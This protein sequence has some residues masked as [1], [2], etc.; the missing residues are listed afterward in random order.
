[1]E[2]VI[3]NIFY[4][5]THKI[6][7]THIGVVQTDSGLFKSEADAE[8][9]NKV[10]RNAINHIRDEV[11]IK[12]IYSYDIEKVLIPETI[13]TKYYKSFNE[14]MVSNPYV[15]YYLEKYDPQLL[16]GAKKLLEELKTEAKQDYPHPHNNLTEEEDNFC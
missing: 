12:Y 9:A 2:K 6:E 15:V 10:L 1:M 5:L 11:D 8:S 7:Y 14:F 13:K 16:E 4:K 3:C